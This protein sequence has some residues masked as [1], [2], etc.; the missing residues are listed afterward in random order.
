MAPWALA[1]VPESRITPWRKPAP[2][3]SRFFYD[4][5]PER[6][7]QARA[8]G[9]ETIDLRERAPLGER[10]A[11]QSLGLYGAMIINPARPDPSLE[12]NHVPVSG[13]GR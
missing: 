7:V 2:K 3:R 12:A 13:R 10:I 1:V 4:M 9:C 5:I 6:L 8:F 11:Q